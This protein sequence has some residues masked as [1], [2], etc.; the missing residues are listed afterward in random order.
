MLA[1][2]DRKVLRAS[3]KLKKAS[4]FNET[5]YLHEEETYYTAEYVN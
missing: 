5:N 3:S 4:R 1:W 2:V